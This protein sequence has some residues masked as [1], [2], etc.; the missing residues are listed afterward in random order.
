MGLK[1]ADNVQWKTKTQ[2]FRSDIMELTD[3]VIFLE[4][5]EKETQKIKYGNSYLKI[6][7]SLVT[8]L[9]SD[10]FLKL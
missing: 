9:D 6:V 7:P 5:T 3:S 2:S 1:K 8:C 4:I 10:Q